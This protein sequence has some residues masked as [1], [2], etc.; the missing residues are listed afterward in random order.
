M[1]PYQAPEHARLC[2]WPG[3]RRGAP[4]DNTL[5][6]TCASDEETVNGWQFRDQV[7]CSVS[8]SAVLSVRGPGSLTGWLTLGTR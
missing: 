5:S 6:R 3:L 8:A 7:S 2:M 4:K 1:A